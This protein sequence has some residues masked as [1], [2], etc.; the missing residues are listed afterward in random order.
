[1]MLILLIKKMVVTDKTQLGRKRKKIVVSFA[2]QTKKQCEKEE[3]SLHLPYYLTAY[4]L[5]NF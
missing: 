1:M 3:L 4:I 5:S 2:K